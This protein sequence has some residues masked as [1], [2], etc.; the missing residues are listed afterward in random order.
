MIGAKIN[1]SDANK[2]HQK[3]KHTMQ[4]KGLKSNHT[5]R[6]VIVKNDINKKGIPKSSNILKSPYMLQIVLLLH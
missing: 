6:L 3:D 4:L 2:V 5:G 1:N